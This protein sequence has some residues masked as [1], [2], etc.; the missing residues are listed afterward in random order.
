MAYIINVGAR[1]DND[2]FGHFKMP[3]CNAPSDVAAGTDLVFAPPALVNYQDG[4]RFES[5]IWTVG[6]DAEDTGLIA[7]WDI[8]NAE[9]DDEAE[10]VSDW[11][12]VDIYA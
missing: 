11:G 6:E 4:V 5:A 9:A 8:D 10:M 1:I 7:A 2:G 3:A 12:N